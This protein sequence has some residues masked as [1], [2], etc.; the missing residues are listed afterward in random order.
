MGLFAT[1]NRLAGSAV[2][3]GVMRQCEFNDGALT[4]QGLTLPEA[5][6]VLGALSSDTLAVARL[7][8]VLPEVPAVAAAQRGDVHVHQQ[9]AQAAPSAP[10][11]PTPAPA[12]SAPLAAP[13]AAP[14]APPV[15]AAPDAA[16]V[17]IGPEVDREVARVDAGVAASPEADPFTAPEAVAA[18]PPPAAPEYPTDVTRAQTLRPVVGWFGETKGIRDLEAMIAA[19]RAIA[20]HCPLV[21]KIIT[22]ENDKLNARVEKTMTTLGYL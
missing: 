7:K 6:A 10:P 3:H 20:P 15:V 1:V 5:M 16:Q 8:G 18:P 14:A 2:V 13:P 9:P 21:A 11:A 4:I 12:P 17:V 22:T 19:V